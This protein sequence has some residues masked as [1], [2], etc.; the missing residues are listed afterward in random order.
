MLSEQYESNE[1]ISLLESL[2]EKRT[3]G[4]LKLK[5]KADLW[6]NQRHCNLVLCDGTITFAGSQIPNN[7]Q[8][9]KILG[10]KLNPDSINAA[11]LVAKKK[12]DTSDSHQK[13]VD[14]LVKLKVFSWEEVQKWILSQVVQKLEIFESHPGET[15]WQTD[16]N[17]DLFDGKE[18]KGSD[19]F[20]I[21][22]KLQERQKKWGSLLPVIP[23]PDGIPFAFPEQLAKIDEAKI[24]NHLASS[25]NGKNTLLDIAEKMGKD[26]LK[27]AKIYFGWVKSGWVG[28]EQPSNQKGSLP[29][30]LSVDDSPIIQT[31]IKR[32]LQSTCH[33]L[34]ADNH[35]KAMEI[36]NQNSIKMLLLDLTM[37]DMDGLEFCRRLREMPKFQD[38]PIVMVT[39]RDGL[40]NRAKGHFAGT[41][42]Y[43]TKPF[44][45]EELR[46]LVD[47]FVSS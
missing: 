28:F 31:M 39:A 30:V 41:N 47:Q 24:K 14:L 42:K 4:I 33:V 26:P 17:F 43:L 45:P 22:Q 34:L 38:L 5:T 23:K 11:L 9:A 44:K 32:S 13:F 12:I 46:E 27:V 35:I 7:E 29:F 18:Q 37:P 19:W 20:T 10:K 3:N 2:L 40:V 15:S 21:K 6:Q 1:L 36:L 8:L 16:K 25:A